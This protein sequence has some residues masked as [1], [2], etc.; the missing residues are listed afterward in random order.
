MFKN[1]PGT[2]SYYNRE[3]KIMNN[4]KSIKDNKT[5]YIFNNTK[6]WIKFIKENKK[7]NDILFIN[8]DFFD[9]EINNLDENSVNQLLKEIDYSLK[10]LNLISS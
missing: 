4:G 7:I 5:G 8:E 1:N 9:I 3:G 2:I 10:K 6:D